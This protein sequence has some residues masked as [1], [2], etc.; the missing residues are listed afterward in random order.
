MLNFCKA[1]GSKRR[2]KAIWNI[3]S[4]H[5]ARAGRNINPASRGYPH[6]FSLS[7]FYGH[8]LNPGT[9]SMSWVAYQN[10]NCLSRAG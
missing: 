2:P 9:A 4:V 7:G 1:I 3:I 5:T 6:R 8:C 10:F